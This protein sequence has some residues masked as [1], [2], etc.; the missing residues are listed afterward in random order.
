M[1]RSFFI[2]I[3]YPILLVSCGYKR[4][5]GIGFLSFIIIQGL[6]SIKVLNFF[7]RTLVRRWEGIFNP[8]SP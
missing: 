2:Q 1:T 3:L 4:L 6:S 5:T 7:P 8:L